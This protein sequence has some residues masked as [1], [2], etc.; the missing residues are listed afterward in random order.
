VQSVGAIFGRRS[1][2]PRS[3]RW[4]Q[5]RVASQITLSSAAASSASARMV[6][7]QPARGRTPNLFILDKLSLVE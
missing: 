1:R 3:K 2:W 5:M 4:L 7:Q 6:F